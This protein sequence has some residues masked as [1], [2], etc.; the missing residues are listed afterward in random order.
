MIGLVVSPERADDLCV[1][2]QIG[3]TDCDILIDTRAKCTVVDASLVQQ[4]DYTGRKLKLTGFYW[5][6]VNLPLA[7]VRVKVGQHDKVHTVTVMENAFAP[8]LLGQDLK[9]MDYLI[10]YERSLRPK[11]EDTAEVLLTRA[12]AKQQEADNTQDDLLS[13]ESGAEPI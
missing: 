10:D 8:V 1:P 3:A 13:A 6:P 9:M 11:K 4:S 12:Q 7:K 2:G 5:R